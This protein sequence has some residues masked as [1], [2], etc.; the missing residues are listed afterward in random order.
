MWLLGHIAPRHLQ[1]I[2][3]FLALGALVTLPGCW[4]NSIN[5]LSEAGVSGSDKDQTFDAGFLGS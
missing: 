2:G 3:I 5:G 1:V 4:V